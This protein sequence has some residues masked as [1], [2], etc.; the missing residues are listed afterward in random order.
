MKK[1]L[2]T[3]LLFTSTTFLFAQLSPFG[4]LLKETDLLPAEG[5]VLVSD[6]TALDGNAL[7]K[8]ATSANTFWY[9]PYTSF[10]GGSYLIQFRLKVSSNVSSNV[11]FTIDVVGG[12]AGVNG[13]LYGALDIRPDMFQNSNEWQLF[14]IPVQ[15]P[16]G[17]SDIELRGINFRPGICDLY[18][19]YA[20]VIP[21]SVSG[22]FS[23]Q[24]TI[25][26]KGNVGI[27]T[28]NPQSKFTVAGNIHAREVKVSVDAGADYVFHEDYPLRPIT[29]LE[30]YIRENKHL[31]E[32]A[33]AKEMEK[34]GINLSDMN[35]KLL[36]KVEELTLYLIDVN[37]K[38]EVLQEENRELKKE[39]G[40][41]LNRYTAKA[42][43]ED[44]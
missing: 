30:T 18:F 17:I 14:T 41:K 19:D 31:P 22:V 11:L 36:R 20:N 10:E 8:P 27:G 4:V 9:G 1:L 39:R 21:G 28:Q 34:D 12:Y 26:P 16:N 25:T 38:V 6:A 40:K 44:K 42:V 15:L 33:S 7:F 24:F 5:A 2:L 32:V 13:R 29:E 35:I 3:I 37:K 23:N 43:L